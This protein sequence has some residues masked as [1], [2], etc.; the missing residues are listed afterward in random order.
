[1]VTTRGS[2]QREQPDL[3]IQEMARRSGFSE[4]TLRYYERIGLLGQVPRDE[5]SGHRRYDPATAERI[6][7]LACLRS[8]GVGIDEMRRYLRLL[9]EGHEAAAD[10]RDLFARNAERISAEIE[11]LLTRRDYLRTKAEMWDARLRRDR[12]AEREATRK[13]DDILQRF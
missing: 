7:A 9:E 10:Q 4:P 8:S 6:D 11:R 13:L 5:G 1:M 3:T 2:V 12:A